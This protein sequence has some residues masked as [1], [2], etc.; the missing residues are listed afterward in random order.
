[1]IKDTTGVDIKTDSNGNYMSSDCPLVSKFPDLVFTVDKQELT[2]PRDVY[3]IKSKGN[4]Y[5]SMLLAPDGD[6]TVTL[7]LPFFY[8]YYTVFDYDKNQV[9][10]AFNMNFSSPYVNT[11]ASRI[12]IILLPVFMVLSILLLV[13]IYKCHKK[14]HPKQEG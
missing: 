7:G 13:V 1:M 11:G 3:V 8:V 2:I 5:Y 9:G 10:T 4:C 14:R 6:D 12:M